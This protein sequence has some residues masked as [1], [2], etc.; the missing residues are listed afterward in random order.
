MCNLQPLTYPRVAVRPRQRMVDPRGDSPDASGLAETAAGASSAVDGRDY[1]CSRSGGVSPGT[2]KTDGARVSAGWR[3]PRRQ[4]RSKCSLSP[5]NSGPGGTCSRRMAC[6]TRDSSPMRN[7][8]L[9]T[10]ATPAPASQALPCGP[11]PRRLPPAPL[12]AAPP[13]ATA[14]PRLRRVH[15]WHRRSTTQA[16]PAQRPLRQAGHPCPERGAATIPA[17]PNPLPF[18][19][20]THFTPVH[21]VRLGPQPPRL[22]GFVPGLPAL[23][24]AP[25]RA[26]CLRVA[27]AVCRGALRLS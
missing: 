4:A 25:W 10:P 23:G 27:P 8:S 20:C 13:P 21:Q 3:R 5:A 18:L 9:T 2:P 15:A 6:M 12:A 17:R 22:F 1:P 16:A 11:L 14:L 24:F 19:P 7:R 26:A